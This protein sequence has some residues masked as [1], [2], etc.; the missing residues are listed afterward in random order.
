[1]KSLVLPRSRIFFDGGLGYI[2]R[3]SSRFVSWIDNRRRRRGTTNH[4]VARMRC[5]EC[6]VNALHGGGENHEGSCF[7][8]IGPCE[9]FANGSDSVTLTIG[10]TNISWNYDGELIIDRLP[11]FFGGCIRGVVLN[12]H[13][14]TSCGCAVI[15]KAK[16]NAILN[17]FLLCCY[18]QAET[19][20][21]EQG[22]SFKQRG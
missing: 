11:I 2:Q 22:K 5:H 4:I 16:A 14:L 18:A 9:S 20:A 13:N 7:Q 3:V 15:A 8:R 10:I 1:M 19:K 17:D 21:S 6:K 12:L